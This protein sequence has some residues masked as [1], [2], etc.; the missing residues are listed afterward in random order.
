LP[1]RWPRAI[2][3]E[4]GR[5]KRRSCVPGLRF[6]RA[7]WFSF[8]AYPLSGGFKP[9]SLVGEGGARRLLR[10]ERAIEPVLGRFMAFR[11]M[12]VVERSTESER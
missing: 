11:M 12:L 3:R 8:A 6:A 2:E 5:G 10:I 9:W 1:G 7:D 4:D